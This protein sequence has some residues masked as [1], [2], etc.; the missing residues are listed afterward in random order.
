M[1]IR[2]QLEI[3]LV[4]DPA[5]KPN[6]FVRQLSE[7]AT[8]LLGGTESV[9]LVRGDDYILGAERSDAPPLGEW[10]A[11]GAA[12]PPPETTVRVHQV[13]TCMHGSPSVPGQ[14]FL[15]GWC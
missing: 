15:C 11:R 10:L 1:R 14:G 12:S 9:L 6:A 8:R 5:A 2:V 13:E 4:V 3:D 7:A